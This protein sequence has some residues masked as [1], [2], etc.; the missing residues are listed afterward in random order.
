M[1]VGM[2]M[3]I[4]DIQIV[5]SSLPEIQ[6]AL[7]IPA[8]SL[9]WIQ[10]AYLIAEV[11]A[12]ALTGWLGRVL[13]LRGLVVAAIGGF[14]AASVACAASD[15]FA[16]LVVAR[17]VQGFFGGALI[18]AVFAAV[19]LLF[20]ER[21][22]ERATMIAGAFAMI[23]PTLGP[24][25]GGWITETWSWHGLFLVNLVPG[26]AAFAFV[27]LMPGVD[28]P[29]L[30]HARRLD[31][32]ALLFLVLFL[33][34]L[35]YVL[36]EAPTRGWRTPEMLALAAACVLSGVQFVRRCRAAAAPLVDLGVLRVANFAPTCA[37]SF[38][39]GAGLYGSVYL[40]PLFLGHVRDLG[41]LAI[42][43]IMI[44]TGAAQL[45]GAP[46]ATY[47]ERRVDPR[48]L[49]GVGYGLFA[50]GLLLG[51]TAAPDSGFA[52]LFWPQVLRGFA[53]MLCLLPTTR[54]ALGALPVAAVENA[55]GLFNLMRNLGGAVALALV[56]TIVLARSPDH[57]AAL[58][59]R[60][61][62]GDA[63]A[64]GLSA[65]ELMGLSQAAIA[66]LVERHAATAAFN[67]AWLFLGAATAASLA[68][69]PWLR[70]YRI[71]LPKG[72]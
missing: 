51:A 25:V 39:L 42:G 67:D 27:S 58:A 69:L 37:Y 63:A 28:Q 18:P 35:E 45:V 7:T 10:T 2:F 33:G 3:A 13:G 70:P 11:V 62:A 5:A 46:V 20:P 43:E 59:G 60:L 34:L 21:L 64:V 44:V 23:A 47:L 72:R 19:F 57:A 49:T 31:A 16:T 6:S 65:A 71:S 12:I 24:T 66:T 53:V 29:D 41:P 50:A 1:C 22:H 30:R 38:L 9:S 40:M 55:S 15:S 32:R 52:D 54:L 36:K 48:M 8:D 17:V 4:L 68:L 26:A 14:T 56:D 61:L